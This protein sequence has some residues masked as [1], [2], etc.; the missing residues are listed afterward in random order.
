[1]VPLATKELPG[2][3]TL[4]INCKHSAE[5]KALNLAFGL[6]PGLPGACTPPNLGTDLGITFH[7][8]IIFT[9]PYWLSRTVSS[10]LVQSTPT[11]RRLNSN[12]LQSAA[13]PKLL[14]SY[15]KGLNNYNRVLGAPY[16]NYSVIHPV[17][18][19]LLIKAPSGLEPKPQPAKPSTLIVEARKLEHGFRRISARIPLYFTLRP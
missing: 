13:S 18:P 11:S 12:V 8:G 15:C 6:S 14:Q 16:Y 1:M 10:R 17:K 9:F 19:I 7:V 2:H 4:N 3:S 5:L